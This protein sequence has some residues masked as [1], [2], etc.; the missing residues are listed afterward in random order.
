ML[1]Y[2]LVLRDEL[3]VGSEYAIRSHP[4]YYFLGKFKSKHGEDVKFYNY[5][6]VHFTTPAYPSFNYDAPPVFKRIIY[7]EEQILKYRIA[8][9]KRAVNQIVASIVG[10]AGNYY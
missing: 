2:R 10:H 7:E 4:H 1:L 6:I 9:E 5:N 8:F 3:V